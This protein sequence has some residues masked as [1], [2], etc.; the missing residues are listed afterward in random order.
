MRRVA[1]RRGCRASS[2]CG[3]TKNAGDD[4][5]RNNPPPAPIQAAVLRPP[6]PSLPPSE[7]SCD[8]ARLSPGPRLSQC[9]DNAGREL[10]YPAIKVT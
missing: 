5:R 4:R 3:E 2:S 8:I 1:C 9:A 6:R 7:L 10:P